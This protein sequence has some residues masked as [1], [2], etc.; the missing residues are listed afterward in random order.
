MSNLIENGF[1]TITDS[2]KETG[3]VILVECEVLASGFKPLFNLKVLN[4][5]HPTIILPLSR[6]GIWCANH[7]V[8]GLISMLRRQLSHSQGTVPP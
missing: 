7:V 6:K 3:S 1:Y 2:D 5:Q 4:Y 8:F